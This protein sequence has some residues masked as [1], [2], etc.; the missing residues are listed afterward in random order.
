VVEVLKGSGALVTGGGSGIG[1]AC[2]R[3]LVDDGATVTICGRTESR[4]RDAAEN[5]GARWVLCD[6]TEEASVASAVETAAEAAGGLHIAIA[7]AGGGRVAG[8]LVLTSIEGWNDT[9]AVNL[10]GT[11]LTIKHAAPAIA[12]S[13][14]GSIVA[15]SSIAG[16]LTHRQLGAYGISKAGI[17]MLVRNAA[18]E[19][20]RYRVRVNAVRPGLVPTDASAALVLDEETREDYLAQMPLSRTGSPDEIANAVRFLAGPESAWITGQIFA[21]DGGHTLR[22]GPDLDH[23]FATHFDNE[24]HLLMKTQTSPSAIGSRLRKSP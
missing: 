22:R 9:L 12:R 6:V 20:G 7:N 4:L 18:D 21:V 15:M 24:L 16:A 2:A 17:E 3:R 13:G 5:I 19:L 23:L 14:G 1:L 10:T 8:P 11:F